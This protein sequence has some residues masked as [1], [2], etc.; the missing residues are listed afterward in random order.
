VISSISDISLCL[1]ISPSLLV[2]LKCPVQTG[3]RS[4][5]ATLLKAEDIECRRALEDSN[6]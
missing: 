5:A 2:R 1:R 3:A 4:P 6:L